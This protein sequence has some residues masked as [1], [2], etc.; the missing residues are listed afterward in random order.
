MTQVSG[1]QGAIA[2]LHPSVGRIA[3]GSFEGLRHGGCCCCFISCVWCVP[4]QEMSVAS[5]RHLTQ[6]LENK[7]C[8]NTLLPGGWIAVALSHRCWSEESEVKHAQDHSCLPRC[9]GKLCSCVLLVKREAVASRVSLSVF[10][11]GDSIWRGLSDAGFQNTHLCVWE[12]NLRR[13]AGSADGQ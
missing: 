2:P 9:R 3:S 7:K 4:G 10:T 13:S 8:T 12:G 5:V 11:F 6:P 1:C